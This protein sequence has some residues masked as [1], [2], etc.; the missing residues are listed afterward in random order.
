MN[1]LQETFPTQAHKETSKVV[2]AHF[3]QVPETEAILL[4]NSCARGQATRDSCIGFHI[5]ASRYAR[6]A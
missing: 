3:Q 5:T 6:S 4:V 1:L 2:A